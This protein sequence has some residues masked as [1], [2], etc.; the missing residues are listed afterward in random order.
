MKYPM[1]NG[2]I[3]LSSPDAPVTGTCNV[4]GLSDGTYITHETSTKWDNSLQQIEVTRIVKDGVMTVTIVEQ[5]PEQIQ[6]YLEN[7]NNQ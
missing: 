4:E 3:L 7:I 6:A 1:P 5:T 2:T